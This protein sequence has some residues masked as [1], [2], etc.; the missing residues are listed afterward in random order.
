MDSMAAG[1][2][3]AVAGK[4]RWKKGYQL[5]CAGAEENLLLLHTHGVA[6]KARNSQAK[7]AWKLSSPAMEV[8]VAQKRAAH[9]RARMHTVNVAQALGID[10]R[11]Y[12]QQ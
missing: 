7:P 11:A 4:Q 12:P 3:V 1:A 2:R 6:G 5:S 10:S 8:L 9:S